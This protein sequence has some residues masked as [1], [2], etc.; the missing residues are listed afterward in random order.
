[1]SR[2]SD[3]PDDIRSGVIE[4]ALSDHVSFADIRAEFDLREDQVKELMRKTLK[5]GSY[6]AW[7]RRVRRM[8]DRREHYKIGRASCRER[9]EISVVAVSLKKK[10]EP[11]GQYAVHHHQT[12]SP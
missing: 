8:S 11:T 4:M 10:E 2:N 3:V 9:G 12:T 1:M 6:K 5:P 7:R